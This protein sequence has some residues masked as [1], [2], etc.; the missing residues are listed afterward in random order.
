MAEARIEEAGIVDAEF[1]DQR[2]EGGHFGGVERRHVHGF[3]GDEDV[4]LVGIEDRA[5]CVPRL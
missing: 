4:E 3:A 1:A 5:R 2:I